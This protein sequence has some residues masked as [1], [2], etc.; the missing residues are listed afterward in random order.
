MTQ[1]E[2]KQEITRLVDTLPE[3]KLA[4]I[5]D[6]LHF[7][8]ERETATDWLWMESQSAAYQ[9]WVGEENDVYDR[10]FANL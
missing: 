7:L 3:P 2:M 8:S 9:E 5:F 6:F 4:L 10:V 1:L